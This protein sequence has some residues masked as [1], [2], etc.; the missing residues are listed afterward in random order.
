MKYYK[1]QGFIQTRTN[2]LFN[3]NTFLEIELDSGYFFIDNG[4]YFSL[5]LIN[6]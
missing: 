4:D 6:N 5:E 2:K 1:D 3:L